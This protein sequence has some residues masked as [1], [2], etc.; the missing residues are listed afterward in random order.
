MSMLT[1]P[2]TVMMP[3]SR[4]DSRRR[5]DADCN[6]DHLAQSLQSFCVRDS[7]CGNENCNYTARHS[8]AACSTVPQDC[9]CMSGAIRYGYSA[10][11]Y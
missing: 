4:N 11:E 2:I 1:K 8:V 9:G 10:L 7:N 5:E 3:L 6:H